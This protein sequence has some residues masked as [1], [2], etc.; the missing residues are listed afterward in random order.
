MCPLGSRS[1]ATAQA[2]LLGSARGKGCTRPDSPQT[3]L[4]EAA[5]CS[6]PV[7]KL[8]QGRGLCVIGLLNLSV[9]QNYLYFITVTHYLPKN[10]NKKIRRKIFISK[11]DILLLLQN[12]QPS[13]QR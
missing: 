7:C 1:E 3:P 6:V 13:T 8:A 2:A 9:T 12:F 5:L 11:W 10:K 4:G